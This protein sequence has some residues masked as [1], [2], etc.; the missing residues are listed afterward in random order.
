MSFTILLLSPDVDPSWPEKIREAVPVPSPRRT[1]IP[2]TLSRTS[3]P[4]MPPTGP[5]R[6]TIRQ[7][8][9]LRWI[10]A[11]RARLRLP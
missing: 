8:E 3:R 7:G 4:P 5:C 2:R 6:R 9:K 10:C 1:P 11:S